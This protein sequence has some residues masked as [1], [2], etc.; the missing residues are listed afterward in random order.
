MKRMMEVC[1][2]VVFVLAVQVVWAGPVTLAVLDATAKD[3]TV[4]LI[5]R[6]D[7]IKGFIDG[8]SGQEGVKVI[9]FDSVTKALKKQGRTLQDCLDDVCRFSIGRKLG[10]RYL[11]TSSI[12]KVGKS[13]LFMVQVW[14]VNTASSVTMESDRTKCQKDASAKAVRGLAKRISKWAVKKGQEK[15]KGK[16]S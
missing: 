9:S 8:M 5:L 14:D 13:C 12:A 16:S 7:A 6:E 11:A 4:D 10:A 2:F 3:S 1:I 15:S